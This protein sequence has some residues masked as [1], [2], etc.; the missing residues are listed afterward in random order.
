MP[1]FFSLPVCAKY[2]YAYCS[3]FKWHCLPDK[4]AAHFT[5]PDTSV[6]LLRTYLCTFCKG[7]S[8]PS[9]FC[10]V[11][12]LSLGQVFIEPLF[13]MFPLQKI[14]C[15][16][17]NNTIYVDV[18]V[19]PNEMFTLY[20]IWKTTSLIAVKLSKPNT[21]LYRNAFAKEVQLFRRF[22]VCRNWKSS[23]ANLAKWYTCH[24]IMISNQ[25]WVQA[26]EGTTLL[27]SWAFIEFL[28]ITSSNTSSSR[29]KNSAY[30]RLN[31]HFRAIKWTSIS[32]V[33]SNSNKMD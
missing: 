3:L 18:L 28:L 11:D 32:T 2:L 31:S 21:P 4:R 5:S 12:E 33:D 26:T 9:A 24:L 30:T 6:C 10:N 29:A 1:I 16:I 25:S 15:K 17:L 19:T 27:T 14:K 23:M 20:P 8:F 7:A 13:R 22:T